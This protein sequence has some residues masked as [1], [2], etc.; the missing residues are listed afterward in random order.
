M[1]PG[2]DTFMECTELLDWL[3]RHGMYRYALTD[4]GVCTLQA[5]LLI[6][7]VNDCLPTP[8]CFNIFAP[9]H[10]LAA[11]NIALQRDFG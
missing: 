5:A 4:L 6:G 1:T 3:E 7:G 11:A 8:V 9:D 10:S 2:K